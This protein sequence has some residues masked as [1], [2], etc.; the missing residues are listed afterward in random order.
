M[1]VYDNEVMV[2]L[3]DIRKHTE[4]RKEIVFV[5]ILNGWNDMGNHK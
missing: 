1:T 3:F 4:G 2:T 5:N